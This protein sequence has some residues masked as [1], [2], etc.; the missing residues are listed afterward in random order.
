[1]THSPVSLRSVNQISITV[2]WKKVA[3]QDLSITSVS[4]MVLLF[5][6]VLLVKISP[7]N[8]T[9]I[10]LML[11]INREYGGR[12]G[13]KIKAMGEKMGAQEPA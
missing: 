6:H 3:S 11:Q 5:L 9:T 8:L 10:V 12:L 1:M 7:L 4:G 2:I 13:D